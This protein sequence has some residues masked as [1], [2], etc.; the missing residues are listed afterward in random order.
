LE[1]TLVY[2]FFPAANTLTNVVLKELSRDRLFSS[3]VRSEQQ[4]QLRSVINKNIDRIE[5]I[6]SEPRDLSKDEI[7]ELVSMVKKEMSGCKDES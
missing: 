4:I 7:V 2:H 5:P 1:Y 3:A 6:R